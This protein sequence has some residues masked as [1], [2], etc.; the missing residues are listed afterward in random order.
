MIHVAIP[1]ATLCSIPAFSANWILIDVAIDAVSTLT[2]LFPIKMVIRSL[3]FFSLSFLSI[4]APAL[5]CLRRLSTVWSARDMSAISLHEKKADSPKSITKISIDMGSMWFLFFKNIVKYI[6][7]IYDLEGGKQW[8]LG[9]IMVVVGYFLILKKN[10][11]IAYMSGF[12]GWNIL[13]LK[14]LFLSL[15]GF[16]CL[17]ILYGLCRS[18]FHKDG[19]NFCFYPI[20]LIG[21]K[22]KNGF[23][24]LYCHFFFGHEFVL[25]GGWF[26][27]TDFS[28]ISIY[29]AKSIYSCFF[30]FTVIVLWLFRISHKLLKYH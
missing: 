4:F 25:S 27:C 10:Q 29:I 1:I 30:V 8:K 3:S 7:L 2:R 22:K 16:D 13:D 23:S 11:Y 18:I 19:K 28:N 21:I 17:S 20:Y 12:P 24:W 14:P 5:R 9:Y 26:F 15:C 6:R